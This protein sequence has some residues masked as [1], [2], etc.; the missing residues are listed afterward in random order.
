M[1]NEWSKTMF[2]LNEMGIFF[3]YSFKY[4]FYSNKQI[5]ENAA[6]M[7]LRS[8][9]QCF[10]YSANT[11]RNAIT[12][13]ECLFDMLRFNCKQTIFFY[14]TLLF[15]FTKLDLNWD[16]VTV[17]DIIFTVLMQRSFRIQPVPFG[18]I[19]LRKMLEQNDEFK[20]LIA[21]FEQNIA[22][23]NE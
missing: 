14:E 18:V 6:K 21:I 3:L 4:L 23:S 11:L 10:L 17:Q 22:N 7:L 15:A 19:E 1:V 2:S 12:V 16:S 5:D 13:V 9:V 20:R 8:I